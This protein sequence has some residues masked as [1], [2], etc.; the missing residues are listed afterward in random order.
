M[1]VKRVQGPN[2]RTG[3]RWGTTGKIYTGP[4][5]RERAAAQGRAAR[6]SGYRPPAGESL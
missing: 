1:P 5:A 6:R 4:D 2:G 3:Y